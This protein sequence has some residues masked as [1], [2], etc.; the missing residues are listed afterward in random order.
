MIV[1]IGMMPH[2]F[3]SVN[4]C[5]KF[6]VQCEVLDPSISPP[7]LISKNPEYPF[8]ILLLSYTVFFLSFTGDLQ[9]WCSLT[10]RD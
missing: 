1:E 3:I 7:S 6:S 9:S 10:V 4:I 5:F 8:K 2:S